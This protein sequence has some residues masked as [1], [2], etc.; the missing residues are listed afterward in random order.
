LCISGHVHQVER[1]QMHGVHYVCNGAVSGG[2]WKGPN[3]G[4]CDAGYGMFNLYDDGS[5]DHDYV[6][7]GWKYHPAPEKKKPAAV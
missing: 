7:Y 1:L 3:Q 6:V 5:F 2:W 4:E